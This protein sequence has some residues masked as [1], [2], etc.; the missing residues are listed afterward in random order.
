M[1]TLKDL[2]DA[3]GKLP[4]DLL[5]KFFISHSMFY[6]DPVPEFDIVTNVIDEKEWEQTNKLFD[7]QE[8]KV[9]VE[10][11]NQLNNDLE[12]ISVCRI[13]PKMIECFVNDSPVRDYEQDVELRCIGEEVA[14]VRE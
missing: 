11:V 13:D 1:K 4:D 8:L 3:L 2:K 10:F 12:K 6:E 9:L 7:Y 14:E 5:D